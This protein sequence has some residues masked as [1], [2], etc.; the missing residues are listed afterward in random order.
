MTEITVTEEEMDVMFA[1]VEE[2]I[3]GA[4]RK[5]NDPEFHKDLSATTRVMEELNHAFAA[6]A[7]YVTF[8]A[9]DLETAMHVLS[10]F[11]AQVS[12]IMT[13][14]T[15]D[16]CQLIRD[17]AHAAGFFFDVLAGMHGGAHWCEGTA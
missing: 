6:G 8:P 12:K 11:R 17:C 10:F 13:P 14:E 1:L 15:P 5:R 4:A 16:D 2:L 9:E 7:S 3:T